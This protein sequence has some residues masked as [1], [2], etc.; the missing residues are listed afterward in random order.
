M[1]NNLYYCYSCRLKDF[2]KSQGFRYE[3][4]GIHPKTNKPFFIFMKSKE[5]DVSLN[6]WNEIKVT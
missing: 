4:K 2:L 1:S 5:L 3:T 6:K